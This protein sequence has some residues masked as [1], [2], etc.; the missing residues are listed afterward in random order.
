MSQGVRLDEERIEML[1]RAGWSASKIA[2][3]IGCA[4]RSV[5]RIRKRLGLGQLPPRWLTS[6]EIQQ[7]EQL[8][9]DGCSIHEIERTLGR[10]RGSLHPRFAGRGWSQDQ[11][12]AMAGTFAAIGRA[13]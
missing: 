11:I 4:K 12:S 1:T 5:Q 6:D 7:A 9:A 3:E 2:A 10:T 8:L 13:S